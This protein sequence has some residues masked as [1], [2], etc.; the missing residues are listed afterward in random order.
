MGSLADLDP[1]AVHPVA[2]DAPPL[3]I[4]PSTLVED[5][6]RDAFVLAHPR[7]T[8]FHRSGWRRVVEAVL[9]HEPADL[10]ARRG[11]RI[12][13]VLPL[14]RAPKL[15]TRGALISI[16]YAVYGGP[17][18]EDSATEQ[19]LV[20]AAMAQAERERC[21]RL[22]LRCQTDPGVELTRSELYATFIAELPSDVAGVLARM[23]KKARAEARKAR[24]KHGLTLTEGAWY[25]EDFHRLFHRNKRSLGSPGLPH[26][27]FWS[28]RK[29]F[30]DDVRIHAVHKDSEVIATVMSFVWRK[31]LLAYYS[32]A[33]E[34]ADRN[35]S[36]SNFMYM[37]L[38]EWAVAQGLERFDFGRSRKD[39]GAFSFKEHQGF[40][41]RDLEYRFHLVRDRA[42]PSLNP[43]NPK[44]KWLRDTWAR[45]PLPASIAISNE[46]ARYLP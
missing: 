2:Q 31:E 10:I 7:A 18:G 30:G 26:A 25:F 29:E 13:G 42:L 39:S 3:V 45:L 36:A 43:S 35:W 41:A 23:P 46:L 15:I 8:F 28:L 9:G 11:E 27:F 19:A 6:E 24:E 40:V 16:P 44:T 33:A 34:D 12:V 17:V 20:R 22:E 32:G 5:A 14:M 37:A 4:A 21:G 38:Q 1:R